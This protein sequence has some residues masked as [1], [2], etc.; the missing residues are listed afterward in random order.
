MGKTESRMHRRVY[1]K[2]QSSTKAT[3]FQ[4]LAK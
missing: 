4:V 1:A 3:G 2:S